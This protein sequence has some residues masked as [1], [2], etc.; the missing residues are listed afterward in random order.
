MCDTVEHGLLDLYL[1]KHWGIKHAVEATCTILRVDH[2]I[3][4]KR[5]G[6]PKPKAGGADSDEE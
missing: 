6:G 3:M 4:A 2:I 1:A 5:A